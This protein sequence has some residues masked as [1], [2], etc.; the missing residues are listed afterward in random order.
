MMRTWRRRWAGLGAAAWLMLAAAVAMSPT[1]AR[2]G[3]NSPWV[4]RAGLS[5]SFN[6]LAIFDSSD[7]GLDR[8]PALPDR[9]EHRSPCAGGACSRSPDLPIRTSDS[10][11]GQMELWGELSADNHP[12][13]PPADGFGFF[14][15]RP[16]PA[17]AV[18]P[19]ERPPREVTPR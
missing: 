10:I 2:A 18:I 5:D 4:H 3:C 1:E 12:P 17:R 11:P 15:D 16:R 19:I 6:E 14:H 9:G 8:D 13:A 7:Q